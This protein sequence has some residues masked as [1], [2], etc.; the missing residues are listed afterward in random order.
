MK[1]RQ[2]AV[3]CL[4]AAAVGA[5]L[6]PL[7]EPPANLV[8]ARREAWT[9]PPLPLRPDG[10]VQGTSV[11]AAPYW[12]KSAEPAT[13]AAALPAEDPRWRIAAIFRRGNEGGVWIEFAAPNKPPQKLKLGDKLPSGHRIVEIGEREI[14]VLLDGKK[15][16]L[17]VERGDV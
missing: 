15:L 3:L 10:T 4:L 1:T 13:A 7:P 9:D 6:A 12:G 11:L 2:L 5:A 14:S 8:G 16:R 17:G